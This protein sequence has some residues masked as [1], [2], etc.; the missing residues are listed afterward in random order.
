MTWMMVGSAAVTVGKNSMEANKANIAG[1][2][3][4]A[5]SFEQER[6]GWEENTAQNKAIGEANLQTTIRTG[7]KVGLANL[8]RAQAKKLAIANGTDLTKN[9]L[10]V[11]GAATANAAASGNVGASVDAVLQDIE[12]QSFEAVSNRDADYEVQSA[13]FDTQ[14]HDILMSGQDALKSSAKANVQQGTAYT[15]ISDTEVLVNS[16]IEIGSQ[17]LGAKMQ[18]GLGQKSAVPE[19]EA[20]RTGRLPGTQ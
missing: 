4:S 7:Y 2:A 10:K 8:Q 14:L 20:T 11:L 1:A 3:G 13:N 16:A 15:Q 6:L 18:L 5:L 9:K 12:Q 17:Y 19:T